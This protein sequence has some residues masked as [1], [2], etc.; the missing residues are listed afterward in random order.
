MDSD[1]IFVIGILTALFSIPPMFSAFIDDRSPRVPAILIMI[2][3]GLIA[4][5][6]Y[7]SPGVYSVKTAPDVFIRVIGGLMN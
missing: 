6:V 3:A 5:A 7:Q 2:A 4:M 1:T